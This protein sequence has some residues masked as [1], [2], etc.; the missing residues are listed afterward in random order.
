MPRNF[1]TIT[2]FLLLSLSFCACGGGE[3]N[4]STTPNT[5]IEQGAFNHYTNDT[6]RSSSCTNLPLEVAT[7]IFASPTGSPAATGTQEDPLDLATALSSNSPLQAGQTLWL[8]KGTY[9]GNFISELTGTSLNPIKVKPLPGKRVI[10]DGNTGVSGLAALRINGEWTEYYGLETMSSSMART[11]AQDTSSP[12]DIIVNEGVS[13]QGANTKVINF[14]VHDNT[15]GGISSWSNAPNSE[16]Y[17]NIIY[18]NGWTAPGRGHGHA[19]YA[20]NTTGYKNLFNNIIFFGFATGIH[21]YTQGGAIEGFN[22]EDNTWFM[23]GSSD[24]RASQKKDNCLIGGFQPVKRLLVKNNQGYSQNA[25][26]SRFGYGGDVTGQDGI[27]ENNY[28]S[29]NLWLVGQWDSLAISDT[30]VHR[31]IINEDLITNSVNNTFSTVPASGKKIFVH[32]NAYDPRRAKIVIYNFDNDAN[33]SVN[34]N[35]V[36]KVGEA[37]RIHSTFALFDS[38]ILEGVYDGNAI[39]IP[40]GT[41]SAPQ[42]TGLQGIDLEEDDPK[43]KFGTFILTHGGC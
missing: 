22:V 16:L 3:S 38:P 31:G 18:N 25:R 15:G 4:T 1:Y 12:S 21:V 43:R 41:V 35:T 13:V 9:T 28:L 37:Y 2:S 20:Q 27:L 42:P 26:G 33:V 29:E 24:P 14:I 36:L 17:G 6:F 7:G 23:T 39:A 32:A 11:S 30:Q 5:P 19:I 34:L 10:L 40:M 8:I